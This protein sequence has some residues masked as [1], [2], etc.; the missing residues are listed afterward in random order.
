[1]KTA[2]CI[3]A[4]LT[5]VAT[6]AD[7]STTNWFPG[8][9]VI[10]S[11]FSDAGD[12]GMSTGVAYVAFAVTNLD[13]LTEANSTNAFSLVHHLLRDLYATWYATASS[14][15]PSTTTMSETSTFTAGETNTITIYTGYGQTRTLTVNEVTP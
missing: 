4:I 14:N 15:R 3:L 1:M 11:T 10:P 12:T 13:T 7:F 5:G 8:S 6:A 2:L 9:V